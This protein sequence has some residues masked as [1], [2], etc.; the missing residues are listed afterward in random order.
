MEDSFFQKMMKSQSFKRQRAIAEQT[1][2]ESQASLIKSPIGEDRQ[3]LKDYT[4]TSK[5]INDDIR[6]GKTGTIVQ[7]GI[8]RALSTL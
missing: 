5:T 2:K 4:M 7:Q 6:Q 3:Y 1:E 8:D